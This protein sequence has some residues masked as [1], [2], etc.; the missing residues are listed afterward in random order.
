VELALQ[1][2]R[3]LKASF[4]GDILIGADGIRSKVRAQLFPGE[5]ASFTGWRIYRGVVE[6]DSQIYDG[7][8]M[9]LLGTGQVTSVLYPICERRRRDGKTLLNWGIN[10]ADAV[11]TEQAPPASTFRCCTTAP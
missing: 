10:C 3:R 5:K 1:S 2:A 11:A 9:L 8:T 4:K 6:I 7:R